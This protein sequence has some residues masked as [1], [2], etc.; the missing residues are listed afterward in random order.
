MRISL[1]GATDGDFVAWV[2]TTIE[3]GCKG[4]WV[5]LGR[6]CGGVIVVVGFIHSRTRTY[7]CPWQRV[8]AATLAM[9]SDAKSTPVAISGGAMDTGTGLAAAVT[10]RLCHATAASLADDDTDFVEQSLLI[11]LVAAATAQPVVVN[12]KPTAIAA[13]VAATFNSTAAAGDF[14]T[15]LQDSALN[16]AGKDSAYCRHP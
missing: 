10:Y 14:V 11:T 4:E 3:A 16:C 2:D 1:T 5:D 6:G 13:G 7:V 15:L 9:R 8:C 12:S